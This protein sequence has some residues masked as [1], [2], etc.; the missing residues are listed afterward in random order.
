LSSLRLASFRV[1]IRQPIETRFVKTRKSR[2][3]FLLE[4]LSPKQPS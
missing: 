2:E 4:L 3:R 1:Q